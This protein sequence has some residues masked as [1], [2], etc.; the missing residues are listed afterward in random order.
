V[1]WIVDTV[2]ALAQ[3]VLGF[4]GFWLVWRVLL[5]ALPGPSERDE[6]IAPFADMFTDA[7]IAPLA[8]RL[9]IRPWWVAA[10]ALT[11]VAASQV[12]LQHASGA[13]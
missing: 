5:P 4:Y 9:H 6:R 3:L 10:V 11:T 12:A 8:R 1:T 13:L 7:V 2:I